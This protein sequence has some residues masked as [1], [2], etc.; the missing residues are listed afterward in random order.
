MPEGNPRFF[1]SKRL[2][3]VRSRET[4]EAGDGEMGVCFDLALVWL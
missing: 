2:Q 4:E 3:V 1:I